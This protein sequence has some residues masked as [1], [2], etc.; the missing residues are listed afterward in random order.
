[1]FLERLLLRVSLRFLRRNGYNVKNILFI[2]ISDMTYKFIK[3]IQ[4]NKQWGYAVKGILYD[5]YP[6]EV[7]SEIAADYSVKN[8]I[9]HKES[10]IN[11]SGILE[12]HLLDPGIDDVISIIK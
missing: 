3:Q 6:S 1:M 9:L 8:T 4:K 5:E 7:F 2:G 12:K 11:D 10:A